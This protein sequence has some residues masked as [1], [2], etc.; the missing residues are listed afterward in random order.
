VLREPPLR[1]PELREPEVREL[2]VREPEL[3]ELELRDPPLREP[4]LRDLDVLRA[5]VLRPLDRDALLRELVLRA[6]DRDRPLLAVDRLVERERV[7]DRV[8]ARRRRR[9]VVARCPRGT[10]ART[11]SLTSR[12]SSASR[13][14]A[15]RS[16][17][18]LI[19]FT[20]WVVSRSP[21]ASANVWM[22]E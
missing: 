7:P 15:I 18:R 21:T 12:P 19:A 9:V 11:S 1:D 10:S 5:P 13:N 2:E 3:R 17:S 14:F 22:R 6:L 8:D 4:E 16:S 20:S